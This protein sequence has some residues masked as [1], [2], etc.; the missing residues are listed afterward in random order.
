MNTNNFTEN[1]GETKEGYK[2]E[3]TEKLGIRFQNYNIKSLKHV[4]ANYYVILIKK[5]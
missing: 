2:I 5:Y 4:F 3:G 1:F